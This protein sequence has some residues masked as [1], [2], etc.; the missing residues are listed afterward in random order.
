M[1]IYVDKLRSWPQQAKSGAE[2]YFGNDKVSCHMTTD[3][4]MEELHQFAK[5]IGLKRSW[6]QIHRNPRFCHYDLTPSK[7]ILAVRLGAIEIVS[8]IDIIGKPK[9]PPQQVTIFE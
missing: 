6:F 2:R 7:R 1:A 5:H 8:I 3:G 4:N 9:S